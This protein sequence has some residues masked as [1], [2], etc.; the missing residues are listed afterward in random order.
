MKILL[1]FEGE[2]VISKSGI[3][4]AFKHQQRALESAGIE[5]TTDPWCP[6]YDI[7]HINT[8]YMN[9]EAIVKNAREHGKKVI[10]HAH[11]TEEDF[12]NSFTLSNTISPAVK[13]WLMHLYTQADALITPTPYS[14]KILEGYGI[15][16]PIFAVS[17]GID[18]KRYQRDPDKIEAFRKY[19]SLKPNDK[20]VIGVGLL[21]QRKGLPDFVEVAKRLPDYKF[22]W[23]GD[24]SRLI[25][26]KEMSDLVD[27]NEIPNLIFPGYVKG[28]IIEGAYS[29]A[30]CFFF[31]S[32]E[33]TEGIVVLEAL[34][35]KCPTVVRDIG[36]FHPW[37][38]DG[39]NCYM[40]SNNDEFVEK[41]RGVVERDLK[42]LTNAGY[43]TAE[44]RSIE[45][46]GQQ[47][48]KVYEFV[49]N[50]EDMMK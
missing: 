8:Y 1:Y 14:K 47:L 17:N 28:G 42:D 23:F 16:L 46:V 32:Y 35:G 31:P 10:Y 41:I 11:S 22:I 43:Q 9:S 5:F 29:D 36:A 30:D 27:N 13:K 6:D 2:S 24:T 21:F 33:E 7:L 44:E 18:L 3:G 38:Q 45:S 20:V 40:G 26:P 4:R 50:H 37:L 39:K 15:Q 12:R 48:K 19:F 34:A 49:M 25:I